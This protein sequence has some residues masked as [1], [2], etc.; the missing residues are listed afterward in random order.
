MFFCVLE[1]TFRA[2]TVVKKPEGARN[3]GCRQKVRKKD[4]RHLTNIL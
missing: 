1:G 3:I 2:P 4:I